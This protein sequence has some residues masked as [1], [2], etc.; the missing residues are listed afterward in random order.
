MWLQVLPLLVGLLR[1]T[2]IFAMF[3]MTA[4]LIFFSR[5][6]SVPASNS[7]ALRRPL[8][9]ALWHLVLPC[10]LHACCVN[11]SS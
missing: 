1:R 10:L 6:R 7:P 5:F 8:Q 11:R 9:G 4:V 2:R 3:L